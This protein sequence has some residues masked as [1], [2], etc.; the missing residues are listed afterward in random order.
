MRPRGVSGNAQARSRLVERHPRGEFDRK[1]GLLAGQAEA[2]PQCSGI[3]H[4]GALGIADHMQQLTARVCELEDERAIRELKARYLRACDLK[5]VDAVRDALLPQGAIIAFEG[6]PVFDDREPFVAVYRE[7]GCAPGIYDIHHGANGEIAFD[8]PDA[9]R[10]RWSL[11]FHNINLAA[12]TLIQMGV[13]YDDR[14]VRRDGRWWIAETR[15]RRTSFLSVAVGPAGEQRVQAM[16][17]APP[18]YSTEPATA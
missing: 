3:G 1:F 18:V 12:R 13:E 11:L 10:G 14:Y 2:R 4:R 8:G 5:D 17:D 6:F 15:S 7:M 9:A 16:G